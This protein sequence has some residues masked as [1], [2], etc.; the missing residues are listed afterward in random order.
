VKTSAYNGTPQRVILISNMVYLLEEDLR[1]VIGL[2]VSLYE[3]EVTV[4]PLTSSLCVK[5]VTCLVPIILVFLLQ[6]EYFHSTL[7]ANAVK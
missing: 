7:P 3:T 1:C 4:P 2:S 5:H 6:S